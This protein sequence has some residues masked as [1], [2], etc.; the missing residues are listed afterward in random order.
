MFRVP[1]FLDGL[2]RSI[3]VHFSTQ[4]LLSVSQRSMEEHRNA[5]QIKEFV[6]NQQTFCTLFVRGNFLGVGQYH[7]S[8]DRR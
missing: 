3:P 2:Y 8:P 7:E 6:Q 1:V 4:V 5:E